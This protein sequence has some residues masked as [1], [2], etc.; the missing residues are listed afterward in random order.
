MDN[1]MIVIDSIITMDLSI[2][3]MEFI[4]LPHHKHHECTI[5][6]TCR[7]ILLTLPVWACHMNPRISFWG[8][9]HYQPLNLMNCGSHARPWVDH[10]TFWPTVFTSEIFC[11]M[12]PWP[13]AK[14][15]ALHLGPVTESLSDWVRKLEISV[16]IDTR[17]C[18]IPGP[19]D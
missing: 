3:D 8:I 4:I 2:R 19:Y 16:S 15:T 14:R 17:A 13:L 11:K 5:V 1:D 10:K 6:W 7:V 12:C 18:S 9:L